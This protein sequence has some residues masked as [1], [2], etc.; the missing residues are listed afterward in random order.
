MS[1]IQHQLVGILKEALNPGTEF[2]DAGRTLK[3]MAESTYFAD[4]EENGD[5]EDEDGNSKSA[6]GGEQMWPDVLKGMLSPGECIVIDDVN[7]SGGTIMHRM[8]MTY[9]HIYSML[10][11]TV[12][13]HVLN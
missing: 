2:W 4:D 7:S 10:K 1:V 6:G 12:H 8:C 5:D 9:I 3:N 13:M 11:H